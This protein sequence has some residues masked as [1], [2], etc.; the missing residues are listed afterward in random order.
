MIPNPIVEEL[1]LPVQTETRQIVGPEFGPQSVLDISVMP[2]GQSGENAP[3][4]AAHPIRRK[5]PSGQ[6]TLAI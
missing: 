3:H 1:G 5:A 4:L 2:V 6:V